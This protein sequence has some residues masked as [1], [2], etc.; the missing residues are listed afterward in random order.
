MISLSK[1]TILSDV[2]SRQSPRNWLEI[3]DIDKNWNISLMGGIPF[4]DWKRQIDWINFDQ[5]HIYIYI[6][7]MCV[8]V[9]FSIFGFLVFES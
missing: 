5:L 1:D 7:C 2:L 9:C 8:C 4:I 6:I 3:R